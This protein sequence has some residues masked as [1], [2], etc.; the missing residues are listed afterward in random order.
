MSNSNHNVT[1]NG[2]SDNNVKDFYSQLRATVIQWL[3]DY[4]VDANT[5]NVLLLLPDMLILLVRLVADTRV[6]ISH[7][8]EFFIAITYLVSPYDILPDFLPPIGLLDD[9][10]VIALVLTRLLSITHKTGEKIVMDNWS[11]DGDVLFEIRY[12]LEKTNDILSKIGTVIV[13]ISRIIPLR[14]DTEV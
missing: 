6:E 14:K 13:L 11:G 4:Q 5:K 9:A 1:D 10:L 8:I 7:K 3:D 12:V 2:I